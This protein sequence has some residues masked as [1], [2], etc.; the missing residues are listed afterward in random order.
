MEVAPRGGMDD[1][2]VA[3][4][5]QSG[6]EACASS[7]SGAVWRGVNKNM[8]AGGVASCSLSRF[9]NQSTVSGCGEMGS[10]NEGAGATQR[11]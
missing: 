2:S 8:E 1:P 7:L 9:F 6:M 3:L 4:L 11:I 10:L 5:S